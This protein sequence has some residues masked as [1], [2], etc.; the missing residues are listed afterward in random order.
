MSDLKLRCAAS[1]ITKI[2]I[3]MMNKIPDRS[4]MI[5]NF[6]RKRKCFSDEARNP[7]S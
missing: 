2:R 3:I 1:T 5:F 4:D 7:L 6:L